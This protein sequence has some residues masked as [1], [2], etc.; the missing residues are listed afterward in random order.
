MSKVE[1]RVCSNKFSTKY[2]T[3]ISGT[4]YCNC[5]YAINANSYKG[6]SQMDN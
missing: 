2:M 6:D 4:Y 5:G 3:L 1:C